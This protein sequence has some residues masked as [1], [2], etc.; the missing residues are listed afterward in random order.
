[1]TSP[2]TTPY[3][4]KSRSP[5]AINT[6]LTANKLHNTSITVRPYVTATFKA[7]LLFSVITIIPYFKTSL[8]PQSKSIFLNATT[9]QGSI[10]PFFT[11]STYHVF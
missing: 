7:I 5:N 2:P 3:K 6:H 8:Y 11:K 9:F 1:M 4:P 10:Y